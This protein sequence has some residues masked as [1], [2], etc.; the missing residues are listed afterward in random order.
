M[1]SNSLWGN[2]FNVVDNTKELLSKIN[3]AQEVKI[4]KVIKSKK[5]STQDKIQLIA[6]NVKNILGSY[7]ENTVVIK[8][9]A[10]FSAYIDEAIKNGII[11]IDT[12]TN[13]SLDPISC[14]IAGL[15][16][17][18]PGQKHAY[19]P[20]NHID[21]NGNR[22]NWQCTEADVAEQLKRVDDLKTIYHNASF[23]KQ[24]I[25]CT[26]NFMPKAYWDTFIGARLLNENEKANLK[27]QYISKIDPSIE[28]YSIEHLFGEV[29]Y[30]VFEPELFALY[31]ATDAYMTLKLYEWQL[32]QFELP[33]NAKLYKLFRTI[34]MPVIDV[35][36]DM[37]LTGVCIDT[38][39]AKRLSKKYHEEKLDE[40]DN[41]IKEELNKIQPKIDAW[42]KTE[43]AVKKEF[44]NGKYQKS[45][46]EQLENPINIGSPTQ[47]AILL[48]DILESPVI[49]KE[50][51]R[52]TGEEI[53]T[54][55]NFPICKLILEKR[56]LEVLINTFID[57][58]PTVINS[59]DNRVHG[60]FN[61]LG[62]D[63]GRFSST[64]PNLQ[65]IPSEETS[66]R[67]MFKPTDGYEMIGA[68][69][70]AQEPRIM[71]AYSQDKYL[72][73]SLEKGRDPYATIA[74][75]IY[76]NNYE[77]NLETCPDGTLYLEGKHRRKS[78][79]SLLLGIMYG[80]GISSIAEQM[81]M[82]IDEA[83][84]ILNDF[85]KG[86]PGIKKWID[87][88]E[89]NAA[90]YGYVEDLWGRKRRLPDILLPEYTIT[91]LKN[92]FNPLLHS[93]GKNNDEEEINQYRLKLSKCKSRK[94]LKDVIDIAKFNGYDIKSNSIKIA[95]A[96][97]QCVNAR[98]QGGAATMTKKAMILIRND[99]MM[100]NLGFRLLLA[101]HDELIGEAPKENADKAKDRL[102]FLMSQA[103]KPEC[104]IPMKCDALTFPCWYWDVRSGEVLE[105]ILEMAVSE[106]YNCDKKQAHKLIDNISGKERNELLKNYK[107]NNFEKV[108][109]TLKKECS[110]L[111]ENQLIEIIKK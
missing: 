106:K 37:E 84:K 75:K 89:E 43:A 27:I 7:A 3:S 104:N 70:S 95:R 32:K 30:V 46:L 31:A 73:D 86:F 82:T 68:D 103:A 41:K 18:T 94:D 23:D 74:T 39:Y 47:M 16:L 9:A 1:T 2:D 111:L 77:D 87:E 98:V 21:E 48:Y 17:Y 49:D 42:S 109:D 25:Y 99:E 5:L 97:R 101:V 61:Q 110:E 102:S 71:A 15:C 38:D 54:Q 72:V 105:T 66:V 24:V 44:K 52:G 40:V 20:I 67:L 10:E 107:D 35:V 80:M 85:F 83:Q 55:M 33:E 81:N 93:S 57:K 63:T 28:K 11:A 58:L 22:L 60:R 8:S 4:E 91:S 13:N 76:H 36:V 96:K 64:N 56:H 62:A 78:V 69:Y 29:P 108:L 51:P 14:K 88:T 59:V 12:E 100:K 6:E 19:I 79:K 45:K 26:C 34:E 65:N 92:S 90:K 50:H 53:I